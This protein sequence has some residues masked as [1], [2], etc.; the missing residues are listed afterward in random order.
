M[1]R[2][3]KTFVATLFNYLFSFQMF[4]EGM[5]RFAGVSAAQVSR[6]FPRID[7]LWALHASLLTK[8][9]NRQRSSPQV[10][11]VADILADTFAP[12]AMNK[13]KAAYGELEYVIGLCIGDFR[14]QLS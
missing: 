2:K 3:Q 6:M 9:R 7:E 12:P 13:L 8:L 10:A 14:L 4:V 11:S 5:M 1:E